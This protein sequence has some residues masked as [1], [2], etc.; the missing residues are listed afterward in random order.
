MV[1][2]ESGETQMTLTTEGPSTPRLYIG[3]TR[4]SGPSCSPSCGR[5][6]PSFVLPRPGCWLSKLN[7]GQ[8]VNL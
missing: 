4:E 1:D 7:P 3:R 5:P 6:A 2:P 8:S